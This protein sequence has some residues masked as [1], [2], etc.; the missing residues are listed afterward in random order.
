[1]NA[2][3][4]KSKTARNGGDGCF[5]AFERMLAYRIGPNSHSLSTVFSTLIFG[6][7]GSRAVGAAKIVELSRQWVNSHTLDHHVAGG[8]LRALADVGTAADVDKFWA[9]CSAQ[10][11]RTHQGWPGSNFN[12]LSDLSRRLSGHGQWSRIAALLS[13]LPARAA[14]THPR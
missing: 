10:L 9:F 13:S 4:E 12:I 3:F 8:V 2:Y 11:G 5:S 7:R 1:M 14:P 6:L